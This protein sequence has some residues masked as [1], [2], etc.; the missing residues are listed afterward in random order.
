MKL[1]RYGT[2]GAEKPG[3]LD[4]NGALRDL[5]GHVSDIA[6]D[7]LSPAGLAKLAAIDP[8]SLP[9]VPGKQRLG[10]CVGKV[11]KFVAVGLNYKDHAGEPDKWPK[12]PILFDKAVSALSG[13]FDDVVLPRGAPKPD[14]EV[15]LGVVIGSRASYVDE[16]NALDHVA[17]YCV[18][19]DVS[20]R[21]WQNERGGQWIKGKSA[22]S[23]GP[24]GPWLVTKD[25]IADV[26]NLP[27]FLEVNG[28]RHQDGNTGN[29]IFGVAFLVSYL[30]QFLTLMPGDII[31]TGTPWGVGVGLTPPQFLKAGDVMRLGIQGLGEQK[32][33]VVANR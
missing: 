12:E 1:L 3:I 22:D 8:A 28:V 21:G 6:G 20:D 14:W 5:S 9:L 33:T 11:S 13:P 23:F 31:A 10:P 4:S 27:M 15:E 2:P 19:N 25:E 24:T 30:S 7:T 29:M 26:Q 17:G 32:Q 16:A 18:V